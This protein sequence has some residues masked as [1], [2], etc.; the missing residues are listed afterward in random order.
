MFENRT[1]PT[2]ED[3]IVL[4]KAWERFQ[5]P[6]RKF[7]K[8][9]RVCFVLPG[10]ILIL[11]GAS[12]LWTILRSWDAS[13]MVMT[14][15]SILFIVLGLLLIFWPIGG[16]TARRNWKRFP[17]KGKEQVYCFTEDRFS[18]RT[19]AGDFEGEY[20]TVRDIV[21]DGR[22]FLLFLDGQVSYILHKD[23]FTSGDS[24]SFRTFLTERTGLSVRHL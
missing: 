20:K 9:Q 8:M 1:V 3:F 19:D 18:L 21:E 5:S 4:Q 2:L 17:D 6:F 16:G 15:I 23:G 11:A 12:N 13:S 24:D 22:V 10:I 7:R 14:V